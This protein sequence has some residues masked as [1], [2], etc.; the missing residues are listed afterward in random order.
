[1][2]F[3]ELPDAQEWVKRDAGPPAHPAG[4]HVLS[5]FPDE[6]PD[7]SLLRKQHLVLVMAEARPC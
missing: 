7:T 2:S 4:F 5:S 6:L 3:P 1:M